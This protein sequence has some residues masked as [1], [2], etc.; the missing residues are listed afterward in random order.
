LPDDPITDDSQDL[1][2]RIGFVDG[3]YQQITK[4]PAPNSFVFGLHGSWGE[5]QTS[6]LNLLQRRLARD[7]SLIPVRF[8]PWYLAS[9]AALIQSFY[10]AIEQALQ[11]RYRVA[12]LHRV[13]SRYG[14]V[15]TSGLGALG[16]K[17]SIRENPERLRSELEEWIGRTGC[18]LVILIDDIDRLSPAEALAVL[19]LAGLSARIQKAI[20][21]LSF[22][23]DVLE[24]MLRD[25]VSIDAAFLE[26][27]VQKPVP[28]PP[29]EPQDL[30]R[31]LLFSDLDGHGAHRSA[32]DRL[33][34]E[35][36]VDSSRRAEFDKEVVYFYHTHLKKLFRTLRDA[37]RYLNSLRATLPAIINEVYLCD[38]FL[39]EAIQVFAP[40][41]YQDIWRHWW[42]YIPSWSFE[43]D[44]GSP[45][46]LVGNLDEKYQ[47]IRTHIAELLKNVPRADVIQAI[48]EKIFFVEVQNAF[49]QGG[50]G[51]HSG[52][53]N[54]YR[55]E[56][57]ITHP[58]CFVKY[59]L[60][61]IPK[62]E[63]PDQAI[64]DL[65]QGWNA[66]PE[67]IV[68]NRIAAALHQ[69]REAGQLSELL[70]KLDLFRGRIASERVPVIIRTIYRFV[71]WLSRAGDRW[72][73]E[74]NRAM[75][76]LFRLLEERAV[77]SNIRPLLEEVVREVPSLYSVVFVVSFLH[78]E[79]GSP[80]RINAQIDLQVLRRLATERL[81]TYF[82]EGN[83]DFFA[84]LP[85]SD[86][87]FILHHWG[88]TWGTQEGEN[89]TVVQSYV[90]HLLDKR[91]AYLGQLLRCFLRANP[92]GEGVGFAFSDLAQ[93]CAPTVINEYLNR[94]G[95]EALTTS[96][97]KEAA[98]LFRQ[99]VAEDEA[100]QQQQGT[101]EQPTQ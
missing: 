63:L 86:W 33:L 13:L 94:Y 71:L 2:G 3:L 9:E 65:I 21:V 37:K 46:S 10:A 31:F 19:K 50:Q 48:L 23:S 54:R 101:S 66:A 92:F 53:A 76:L 79:P 36:G 16:L 56:K 87:V 18:R 15:L 61:K 81:H 5:G 93:I 7:F 12:G 38:F 85:E 98:R 69:Y 83:R 43:T 82:I 95:D 40:Q 58:E 11:E 4:L 99:R 30:D 41:V 78:Q 57:R 49:R 97:A 39:L 89:H 27:I 72:S 96:E 84:E 51:D 90:M 100:G 1:L 77:T 60:G 47:A 52:A 62:G 25:R 14:E 17:L 45:F 91:P 32:I 28:L 55:E 70:T 35:L 22:D 64:E 67:T 26:K 20:F 80:S 44:L 74:H 75:D 73:S 24:G 6:V 68:E 59:F 29:A 42:C 34:D 88:T 8:N